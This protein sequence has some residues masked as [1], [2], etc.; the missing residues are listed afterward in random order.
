MKRIETVGDIHT[1]YER[2]EGARVKDGVLEMPAAD[3]PDRHPPTHTGKQANTRT[4]TQTH[5]HTH[6]HTHRQTALGLPTF[7][8]TSL[9]L[10]LNA[11]HTVFLI[12][13][14]SSASLPLA[15]MSLCLC[16]YVSLC[17]G[18]LLPGSLRFSARACASQLLSF[19]LA[20]SNSHTVQKI[21][22][23]GGAI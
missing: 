12:C 18:S 6:T 21:Y 15:S 7:L 1:N 16:F 3:A 9:S 11:T 20:C 8:E 13:V 5:T 2:M 19:K 4:Q 23:K 14:S 22:P 17:P 10:S